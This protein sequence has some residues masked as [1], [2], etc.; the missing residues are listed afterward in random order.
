M[1]AVARSRGADAVDAVAVLTVDRSRGA[2]AVDHSRGAGD[3]RCFCCSR[4]W[5]S[6]GDHRRRLITVIWTLIADS[7]EW[8][9]EVLQKELATNAVVTVMRESDFCSS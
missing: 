3:G 7:N 1:T 8:Q 4:E 5:C 2:D 9:W 6:A